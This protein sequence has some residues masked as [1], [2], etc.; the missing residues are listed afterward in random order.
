MLFSSSSDDYA[1]NIFDRGGERGGKENLLCSC[2]LF[3]GIPTTP[4]VAAAAAVANNILL[5][6]EGITAA[7]RA[8]N[9]PAH[10]KT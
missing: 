10:K 3:V 1:V 6:C 4:L 8:T 2:G 5:T 9:C 7:E